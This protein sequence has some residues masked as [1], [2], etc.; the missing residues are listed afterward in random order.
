MKAFFR[1]FGWYIIGFMGVYIGFLANRH[2]ILALPPEDI[3][4]VECHLAWDGL[5]YGDCVADLYGAC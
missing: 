5:R 1:K 3:S 2:S 4:R